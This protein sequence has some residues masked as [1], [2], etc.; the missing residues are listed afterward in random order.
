MLINNW[1]V[2]VIHGERE[3]PNKDVERFR[4]GVYG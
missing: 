3:D 2:P 1:R 4:D